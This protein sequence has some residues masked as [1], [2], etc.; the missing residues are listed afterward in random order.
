M[1]WGCLG[2]VLIIILIIAIISLFYNISMNASNISMNNYN[3]TIE[4]LLFIDDSKLYMPLSDKELP[5]DIQY[6]IPSPGN[7]LTDLQS[8]SIDSDILRNVRVL[9][10]FSKID[11]LDFYQM[12]NILKQMKNSVYN[13]TYDP[14]T[15]KKK[16]HIISSEKL[17]ALNSGAINNTD[18]ELFTTI[19]LEIIS[20][21]N[22][23]IIKTGYYTSYHPYQFFKI[24]NSNMIF[25]LEAIIYLH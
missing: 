19:K 2:L 7:N 11:E 20:A 13:I 12:Y 3:N 10:N 22:N 15:I 4:P 5:S 17:I 24:I 25:N 8:Q 9:T 16:S 6:Q 1:L 18:L 21:F 23:F 14:S